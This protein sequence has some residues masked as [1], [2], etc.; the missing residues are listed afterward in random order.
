M[1]EI[2]SPLRAAAPAVTQNLFMW[3]LVA[4][5]SPPEQVLE[6]E[7]LCRDVAALLKQ[8]NTGTRL[9]QRYWNAMCARLAW[10]DGDAALPEQKRFLTPSCL[11]RSEGKTA[12]K[13]VYAENYADWLE[14]IR[15]NKGRM[16][17]KAHI[18]DAA[19]LNEHKTA[20]EL[21]RMELTAEESLAKAI[22]TN[23][24]HNDNV[25]AGLRANEASEKKCAK[26][27]KRMQQLTSQLVT[28]D[29][30][31]YKLNPRAGQRQGKHKKG[32]M[33][34]WSDMAEGE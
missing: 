34:K 22:E 26:E 18:T 13:A 3:E 12:W 14:S 33:K 5:F 27:S 16:Q 32:G 1:E 29:R 23:K 28:D 8:S 10:E 4:A 25:A 17:R 7:R 11:T 21:R 9:M 19:S 15:K 20:E 24:Q 6:I 31:R 2:F 30:M